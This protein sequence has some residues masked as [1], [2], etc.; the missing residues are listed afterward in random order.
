MDDFSRF[1]GQLVN[2]DENG[3]FVRAGGVVAQRPVDCLARLSP[4]DDL[5]VPKLHLMVGPLQSVEV[6]A[7]ADDG[8]AIVVEIEIG[9]PVTVQKSVADF[10]VGPVRMPQETTDVAFEQPITVL[11]EQP[12]D[13]ADGDPSNQHALEVEVFGDDPAAQGESGVDMRSAL[14]GPDDGVVVE[15]QDLQLFTVE[16]HGFPYPALRLR[17]P[18]GAVVAEHQSDGRDVAVE[19]Q[20][21]D[22]RDWRGD[23]LVQ[24]DVPVGIEQ[25]PDCP[26][27]ALKS[28][29]RE[30]CRTAQI[31]HPVL[32]LEH[33]HDEVTLFD[34]ADIEAVHAGIVA[35]VR[36][37]LDTVSERQFERRRHA[38]NHERSRLAPILVRPRE[39]LRVGFDDACH[40]EI[41]DAGVDVRGLAPRRSGPGPGAFRVSGKYHR[42]PGSSPSTP[43]QVHFASATCLTGR[44]VRRYGF[45]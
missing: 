28:V 45:A 43:P 20:R 13:L 18:S 30:V 23:S 4:V 31:L 12:M 10:R 17:R 42:H 5:Q 39:P 26:E 35:A 37:Q 19:N 44:T 34:V 32:A 25:H 2:P 6:E 8:D 38:Q 16:L 9:R 14:Q 40:P 22:L 7:I 36:Q 21:T 3:G 11:L 33:R 1:V 15:V 41:D 29:L 24:R 27:R